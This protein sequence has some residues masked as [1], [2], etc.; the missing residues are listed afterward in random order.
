MVHAAVLAALVA[1]SSP[2]PRAGG[3]QGEGADAAATAPAPFQLRASHQFLAGALVGAVLTLA[4]VGAWEAWGPVACAP[5]NDRCTP[6]LWSGEADPRG[7]LFLIALL[8]PL[9]SAFG[10]WAVGRLWAPSP[11]GPW[12]KALLASFA[13][14]LLSPVWLLPVAAVWLATGGP[15]A[16]SGGPIQLAG[17]TWI[18]AASLFDSAAATWVLRRTAGGH[19]FFSV[20]SLP[21]A[22]GTRAVPAIA[23]TF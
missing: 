1:T 18:L 13:A 9:G 14:Q 10:A 4:A 8:P 3:G 15:S 5:A 23:G 21:A 16:N 17:A 2:L 7:L 22:R 12:W 11:Q 6:F 20:T 19:A